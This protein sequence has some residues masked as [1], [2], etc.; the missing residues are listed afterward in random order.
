MGKKRSLG[1]DGFP[2]WN[3]QQSD[4]ELINTN[5]SIPINLGSDP[6]F[7]INVALDWKGNTSVPGGNFMMVTRIKFVK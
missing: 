3:K 4:W 7:P 5:A 6:K 1:F 2:L